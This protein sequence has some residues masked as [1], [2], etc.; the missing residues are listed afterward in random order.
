MD[1]RRDAPAARSLY[2]E[3]TIESLVVT[4]VSFRAASSRPR[5][6]RAPGRPAH[7]VP[8]G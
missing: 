1:R 4:P 3:E 6:A 5:R 8:T 2:Q 7:R